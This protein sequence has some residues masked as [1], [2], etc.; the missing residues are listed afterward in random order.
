MFQMPVTIRTANAA[1]AMRPNARAAALGTSAPAAR[2]TGSSAA[3]VIC[4]PT[5]IAAAST[6]RNSRTLSAVTGSMS[7]IVRDD[8]LLA[9]KWMCDAAA[10]RDL[11]PHLLGH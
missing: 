3:T 5:Q 11:H 2:R 10:R 4:P 8:A 6:W 1:H 7:A 9:L